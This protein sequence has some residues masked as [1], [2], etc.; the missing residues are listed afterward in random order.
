M[1]LSDTHC[2]LNLEAY[3]TDRDDVIG[4]AAAA[5]VERFLVIGFDLKSSLRASELSARSGLFAAIGI[6][7]ESAEEWGG[8]AASQLSAMWAQGG[9]GVRAYGEIGLD[10][11]WESVP[12]ARQQ[13]VFLEQLRFASDLSPK[14]PVIIHCREAFDDVLAVLAESAVDN[15]IVMHCFIGD[16]RAARQCVDR[17]YT[18]GIG[19]VL[20]YKKSVDLRAAVAS[21]PM[22]CLILETD[23]PYLPPQPWRG[24]R[25]EPSYITAVAETLATVRGIPVAEVAEA[26]ARNA[27]RLFGWGEL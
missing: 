18:L 1:R 22:D 5:G 4:R 14:L 26:T 25:N 16:D 24:K 23:C 6:H 11:H 9:G 13:A 21:V 15:P 20:T 10:Y 8:G 2:H 7:P 27:D 19:G 17:G 3:D 12:R